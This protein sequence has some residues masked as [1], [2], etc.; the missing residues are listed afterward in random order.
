MTIATDTVTA[1]MLALEAGDFHKATTYL[2]ENFSFTGWT[3]QPLDKTQFITVMSGLK[4]GMPNLMYNFRDLHEE[5]ER[6]EHSIEKGIV[7]MSGKQANSFNLPPLSLPII[8]QMDGTV[9]LPEE[10][11]SFTLEGNTIVLIHVQRVP[12]GGI[13]GVIHQLGIDVEPIQ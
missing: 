3:P 7:Q 13:Q 12:G 4:T 11:W 8:P 1:F 9:S 5:V 10:H 6:D 2:S